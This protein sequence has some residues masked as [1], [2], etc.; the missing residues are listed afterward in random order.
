MTFVVQIVGLLLAVY[1]IV[2]LRRVVKAGVHMTRT[3]DTI[4]A[5]LADINIEVG[6]LAADVAELVSRLN[7]TTDDGL[8]KDEA[9]ALANDLGGLR[10]RLQ[11]LAGE[12]VSSGETQQP[13]PEPAPEL[14][15]QPSPTGDSGQT[16]NQ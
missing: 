12:Y 13:A 16:D 6:N 3:F 8:T 2:V 7:Q 14:P 1:A 10:D 15:V 11:T 5:T 9:A 4:E